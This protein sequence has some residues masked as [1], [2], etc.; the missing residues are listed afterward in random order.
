MIE[1]IF[2]PYK[3]FVSESSL[4]EMSRVTSSTTSGFPLFKCLFATDLII[5]SSFLWIRKTSHRSIYF[6]ESISCLRSWIFIWMYFNSFFL[7]CLFEICFSA[8]F[9]NTQHLV[10]VFATYNFLANSYIF[11]SVL[12]CILR[13]LLIVLALGSLLFRSWGWSCCLV[14]W[15][16]S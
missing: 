14:S 15:L 3:V 9:F 4:S 8:G 16:F 11:L 7:K 12:S 1:D 2:R 13:S 6:L 10:V 5:G